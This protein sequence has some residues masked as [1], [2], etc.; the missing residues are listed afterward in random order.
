[1]KGFHWKHDSASKCVR[2]C[3][4]RFWTYVRLCK[5]LLPLLPNRSASSAGS[6]GG[7]MKRMYSAVPGRVYVAVRS[8]SAS[9]DRELSLNKGDKVKGEELRFTH[10]E[11]GGYEERENPFTGVGGWFMSYLA[12]CLSL[13]PISRFTAL[14]VESIID[15]FPHH[16]LLCFIGING[17]ISTWNRQKTRQILTLCSLRLSQTG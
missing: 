13:H 8:H 3:S 6:G 11:A 5:S 7:Q 17:I 1:M 10:E 4:L 2:P 16:S 15:P 14:T 12:H 9:G